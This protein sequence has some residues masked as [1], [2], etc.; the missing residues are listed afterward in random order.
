[1]LSRAASVRLTR[2]GS[3]RAE[4]AAPRVALTAAQQRTVEITDATTVVT[5][6]VGSGKTTALAARAIACRGSGGEPLIVCSHESGRQAF[7]EALTLLRREGDDTRPYRIATL[8]DHVAQWLCSSYLAAGAA[9]QIVLGGKRVAL[10]ILSQAAK[11][12]LDMTW[13]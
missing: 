11:G 12:L 7:N 1:M 9:P 10:H 4:L 2:N 8:A 6:P 3:L 13:P 5:G